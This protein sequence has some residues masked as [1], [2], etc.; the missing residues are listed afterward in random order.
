M[1]LTVILKSISVKTFLSFIS[2]S[3][4][5]YFVA[6]AD[7]PTLELFSLSSSSVFWVEDATVTDEDWQTLIMV[8]ILN[9]QH[10]LSEK[11]S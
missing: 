5:Q 9:T 1:L 10:L 4:V 3:V 7:Q 2:L 11:R 6:S 8:K